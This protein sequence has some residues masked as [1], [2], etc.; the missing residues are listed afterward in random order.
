MMRIVLTTVA[1]CLVRCVSGPF[2]IPAVLQ[3]PEKFD[4]KTITVTAFVQSAGPHGTFLSDDPS[5][6]KAVVSLRVEHPREKIAGL[7]EMTA[8]M[9]EDENREVARGVKAEFVGVFHAAPNRTP[10]LAVSSVRNL[11][12]GAPALR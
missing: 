6:P 12:W 1:L 5:D 10:V 4:G 8:M 3:T 11:R 2:M 9:I 7:R